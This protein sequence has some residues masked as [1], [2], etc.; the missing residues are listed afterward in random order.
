MKRGVVTFPGAT[1]R[2]EVPTTS[3]E[4]EHGLRGRTTL[5]DDNGMLFLSPTD[6]EWAMTMEGVLVPLVMLFLD[7]NNR[8]TRALFASPGQRFLPT[9]RARSVL[10]VTPRW[11]IAKGSYESQAGIWVE[12]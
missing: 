5:L 2:V 9:V 7:G 8:I 4:Q 3:Q 11:W 6:R 12:A 1:L 10:E